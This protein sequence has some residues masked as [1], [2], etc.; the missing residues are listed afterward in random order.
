VAQAVKEF[1]TM[2][3]ISVRS[4]EKKDTMFSEGQLVAK[5]FLLMTVSEAYELF[6][7][8]NTN[9][10]LI[11]KSTFF[12]LRPRHVQLIDKIPYNICVCVYHPNFKYLLQSLGTIIPS[13][14]TN[15]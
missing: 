9:M 15:F 7:N 14:L 6:K 8:E 4:S 3:D 2:D 11:S 13:F 1:Y 10:E 5:R 12:E